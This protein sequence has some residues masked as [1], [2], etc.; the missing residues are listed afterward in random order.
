[1]M[2]LKINFLRFT[3][4]SKLSKQPFIENDNAQIANL[5][6]KI[7]ENVNTKLLSQ[8][9]EKEKTNEF[10]IN[11][12]KS[13]TSEFVNNPE[14]RNEVRTCVEENNFSDRKNLNTDT[15]NSIDFNESDKKDIVDK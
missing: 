6:T 10:L 12:A 14:K 8:E 5:T 11:K 7:P 2:F 13:S 3:D 15:P 4:D 9:I 1:M